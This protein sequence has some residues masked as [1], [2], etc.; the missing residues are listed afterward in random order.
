MAMDE[1]FVH[2][3]WER[4]FEGH[5]PFALEATV[6]V[7]D[8]VIGLIAAAGRQELDRGGAGGR[9]FAEGLGAALAVHLL[10]RYGSPTRRPSAHKGGL[11][12]AQLRRVVEYIDANLG[13][14]L[15]L[16]DLAEI[17]GLS[18][19]HF[20]EVFKATTGT[21]PHRYVIERRTKR[22]RDLLR[23][24]ARSIADIAYAAGFSS[25]SHLTASF[26]RFIGLTP[27][28]FRRSLG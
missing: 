21:S 13:E 11:A 15:G 28:R 19:H 2:A 5:G 23:D 18:P 12:P 8:P 9:L 3:I 4:G 10:R 16:V 14:P 1:A 27:A 22:A 26:R 17:A 24:P 20:G 7:D 6:G 25:Q